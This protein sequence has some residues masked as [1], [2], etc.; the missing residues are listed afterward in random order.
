MD[1]VTKYTDFLVFSP[2]WFIDF[3]QGELDGRDLPGLTNDRIKTTTVSGEHPL[4]SLVGSIFTDGTPNFSGRLPAISVMDSEETEDGTT[5]GQG[6]RA[7]NV[8]DQTLLDAISSK[9]IKE[10]YF[11]G[12]ISD[13]Q[14]QTIQTAIDAETN[15]QLL[16]E[17]EEFYQRESVFVSLWAHSKQELNIIGSLLRS[18]LYEMKKAR[19]CRAFA[20]LG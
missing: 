18:I 2:D 3:I 7:Y 1:V 19:L 4:V 8:M 9:Q 6:K 13:D 11:D 15:N 20:L 12:L 10:R 5:I 16:L 17:V 14:I